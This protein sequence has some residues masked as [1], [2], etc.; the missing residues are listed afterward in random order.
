EDVEAVGG[1][2]ADPPHAAPE[3]HGPHLRLVVLQREVDVARGV[4][5]EVRDLALHPEPAEPPLKGVLDR[6]RPLPD[7]EDPASGL[8]PRARQDG[9]PSGH[10]GH[11]PPTAQQRAAAPFDGLRPGAPRP[12]TV[13]IT[14]AAW[15]ILIH[16]D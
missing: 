7:R 11:R 16:G 13:L 14:R 15:R 10:L 8:P 1:L 4:D 5:A 9:H 12:P 2:E 3:E 6:A